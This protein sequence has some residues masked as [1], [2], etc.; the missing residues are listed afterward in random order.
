[1]YGHLGYFRRYMGRVLTRLYRGQKTYQDRAF[2]EDPV[3]LLVEVM[4]ELEDVAGWSSILWERLDT[5][6]RQMLLV[7]P[8]A[9]VVFDRSC[10]QPGVNT[11][12]D[13]VKPLGR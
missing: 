10:D 3:K 12:T 5:I 11:G 4:E 8:L 2:S 7:G 1:M 6:K 13:V 9:L